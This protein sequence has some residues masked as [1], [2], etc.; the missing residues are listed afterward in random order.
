MSA[1]DKVRRI[2]VADD[3]DSLRTLICSCLERSGYHAFPAST[4]EAAQ[5]FV[6]NNKCDLVVTDIQMPY[7]DGINLRNILR[8]DYPELKIIVMSGEELPMRWLEASAES[9]EL[10]TLR[11]PFDVD[12]L[13]S[14]V[15]TALNE[16]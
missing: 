16:G 6:K 9:S 5:D 8:A 1:S 4:G 7:G 11:K 2:L 12:T 15:R 13:L 10:I 14:T 3:D